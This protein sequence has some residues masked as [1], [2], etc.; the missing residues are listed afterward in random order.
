VFWI[1]P[2]FIARIGAVGMAVA[3]Q[4]LGQT[5]NKKQQIQFTVLKI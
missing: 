5:E 1:A 3:K 4:V 2:A